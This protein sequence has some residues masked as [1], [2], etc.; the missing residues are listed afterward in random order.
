MFD[1]IP[2]SPDIWAARFLSLVELLESAVVFSEDNVGELLW[3]AEAQIRAGYFGLSSISSIIEASDISKSYGPVKAVKDL[4][5]KVSAGRIYGLLGPNGAGKTTT[6]RMLAGLLQ[7][8][9]GTLSVFGLNLWPNLRLIVPR[10]GALIEAPAFYPYLSG[11]ENLQLLASYSG[12][13]SAWPLDELLDVVGLAT[14]GRRKYKSYSLGMQQRLGLASALL[15]DPELLLL[16]EPTI[17]LDP[18]GRH[19]VRRL[20]RE[21]TK[22]GKTVFLSSHMLDEVEELCDEV[23]V[24][25]AGKVVADGKVAT[26]LKRGRF[27][28]LKVG[29]PTKAMELLR[30]ESWIDSVVEDKDGILV[31]V[32]SFLSSKVTAFLAESGIYVSEIRPRDETLED[33]FLTLVKEDNGAGDRPG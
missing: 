21:Q 10:V 30:K 18:E 2:P 31:E 33:F 26:L 27:V 23:T 11:R 7:P 13:S 5:L 29:D 16:D 24:M 9:S 14:D 19:D 8:D 12:P 15:K 3:E 17:G 22:V 25:R 6:L 1:S 28:H 20:I 32:P 4:N